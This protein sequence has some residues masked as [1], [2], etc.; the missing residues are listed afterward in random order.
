[1]RQVGRLDNELDANVFRDFLFSRGITCDVEA[2]GEGAWSLWVHEEDRLAEVNELFARFRQNPDDHMFIAG[3][4]SGEKRRAEAEKQE[5]SSRRQLD[6][7]EKLNKVYG[8][9]GG[10]IATWALIAISV[11]VYVLMQFG[12]KEVVFKSL[13]ISQYLFTPGTTPFLIEVQSG[14]LWRLLTPVFMHFGI[15]HIIFNMM[16]LRDLGS[17]I[18]NIRGTRFFLLF[19]V[20]TAAASNVAQYFASGPLFGG[21]SGVVYGL[22]GFVWM[23]SRFNPWSGFV[24]H[25]MT[26]Q[27]MLFWYV[28]C[29]TG[30]IGNIANT[31]HTVGLLVGV[32]WGYL[33]ARQRA[34]G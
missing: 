33:D 8:L 26:V 28:L 15:L 25:S 30:V 4:D 31:T 6:R 29:L 2:A 9:T 17:M 18:E 24:L 21:M 5:R 3:A 16:W 23:Q 1:M 34:S 12:A 11:I 32:A 19:L 10:G 22:L 7:Q 13:M 27:M 14:Q 20:L